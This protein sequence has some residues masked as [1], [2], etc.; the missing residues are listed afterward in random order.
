MQYMNVRIY[1]HLHTNGDQ[2]AVRM[3]LA[4]Q[5]SQIR[6]QQHKHKKIWMTNK[7]KQTHN[8]VRLKHIFILIDVI[9][10]HKLYKLE[11]CVFKPATSNVFS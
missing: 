9:L 8:Y 1:V 2:R 3:F 6:N 4:N 7:T 5:R 10:Q 11:L